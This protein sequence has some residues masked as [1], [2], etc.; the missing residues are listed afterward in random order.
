MS[1]RNNGYTRRSD[2]TLQS[3]TRKGR[4]NPPAEPTR[5]RKERR[6]GS[7]G[8]GPQ[9]EARCERCEHE[10]A[11]AAEVGQKG[12]RGKCVAAAACGLG[13]ATTRHEAFVA[14]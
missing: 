10:L 13:A 9:G 3:G 1:N 11:T 2:G 4:Y 7:S 12:G 14:R 8:W 5:E 6:A